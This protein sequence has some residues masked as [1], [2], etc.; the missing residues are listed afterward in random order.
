[1]RSHS[2]EAV[3]LGDFQKIRLIGKGAIG[4]VYV[5]RLKGTEQLY[6]MKVIKKYEMIQRNKV[7]HPSTLPPL[8]C[9][10][11]MSPRFPTF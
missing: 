2:K 10:F 1:M 7:K 4:N 5:S 3:G 6:A 8:R 9:R 11:N